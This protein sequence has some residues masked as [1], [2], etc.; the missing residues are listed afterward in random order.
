M[1]KFINFSEF[2]HYLIDDSKQA[3]KAAQIVQALLEA[4]SPRISNIVEKMEG[5]S[6][7]CCCQKK[8]LM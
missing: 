8:C 1:A 6:E 2:M 4:Q 3:E 7:T 5:K